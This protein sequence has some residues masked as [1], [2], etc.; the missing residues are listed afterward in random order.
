MLRFLKL[1]SDA[2]SVGIV[3]VKELRAVFFFNMIVKVQK[4]VRQL[5]SSFTRARV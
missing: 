3:P 5:S 1:A 4:M 2:I